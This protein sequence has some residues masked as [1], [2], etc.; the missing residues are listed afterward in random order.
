MRAL[1]IGF[2]VLSPFLFVPGCTDDTCKHPKIITVPDTKDMGQL[3]TGPGIQ[4][5]VVRVC[6]GQA[7]R[8]DSRVALTSLE[9]PQIVDYGSQ[10]A[11]R[12]KTVAGKR[13]LI[14][15]GC[16]AEASPERIC[17][18]AGGGPGGPGPDV[19][20]P[21]S[22]TIVTVGAGSGD[23]I[24]SPDGTVVRA[25]LAQDPRSRR[26]LSRRFIPLPL[27]HPAPMSAI[28]RPTLGSAP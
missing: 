6:D 7:G 17:L 23:F 3:V 2:V 21:T 27:R 9:D 18:D 16:H 24:T 25:G 28:C 13:G 15:P 1:A 26:Q 4:C 12:C 19:T 5:H 11:S 10:N 22:G 14:G 8:P 20:G